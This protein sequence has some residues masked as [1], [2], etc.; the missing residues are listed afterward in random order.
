MKA[1][2]LPGSIAIASSTVYTMIILSSGRGKD[3]YIDHG[4]YMLGF[5]LVYALLMLP[6]R[7]WCTVLAWPTFKTKQA[8]ILLIGSDLILLTLMLV[9]PDQIIRASL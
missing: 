2:L 6:S 3:A 4:L 8:K 1:L 9:V 5:L 7:I